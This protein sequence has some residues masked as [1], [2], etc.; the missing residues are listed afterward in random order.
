MKVKNHGQAKFGPDFGL[1]NSDLPTGLRD[2]FADLPL[3]PPHLVTENCMTTYLVYALLN[4]NVK[5]KLVV[6]SCGILIARAQFIYRTFSGRVVLIHL[7][8]VCR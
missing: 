2:D 4:S 1:C 8:L 3:L 5:K 7:G 6:E